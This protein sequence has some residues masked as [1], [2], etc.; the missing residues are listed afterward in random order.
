MSSQES[1]EANSDRDKRQESQRW[2]EIVLSDDTGESTHPYGGRWQ[3]Q[4]KSKVMPLNLA[5]ESAQRVLDATPDFIVNIISVTMFCLLVYLILRKN[6]MSVNDLET[7]QKLWY[8][9]LTSIIGGY[10][11]RLFQLPP[12]FGMILASVIVTNSSENVRIPDTWGETITSSGLAIILL[13]SGL[14]LDLNGLKKS[15]K[16]AM[17]LTCIPGIVEAIISGLLAVLI[18]GFPFWLGLSLGF[19][20]AAVSPALVVVGM[21]KLQHKGYGVSKGIPSLVIAAASFDD[22]VA[23][24]GFSFFIGLA[25]QSDHS[26]LLHSALH[27]PLSVIIGV[28]IGVLGGTLLSM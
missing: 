18:F 22:I 6:G 19:I 8:L 26:T 21:L 23:I 3:D 28:G 12:L 10:V 27:G 2:E 25:I 17:R 1:K 5:K 20:L 7:F 4:I 11:M 13:L 16:Q 9:W 24:T 15:S 14:E